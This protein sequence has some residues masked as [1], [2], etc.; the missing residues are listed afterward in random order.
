MCL[1]QLILILFVNISFVQ[2]TWSQDERTFRD[3]IT[4]SEREDSTRK[5]AAEYK[6][7]V[8]SHR[9]YLDMNE[10]GAPESFFTSK[11]DGEDWLTLFDSKDREV[12]RYRFETIGPWSRLFRVQMRRISKNV[13]VLLLYFFEGTTRYINF[14]GTTRVYFLTLENNDFKSLSTYK[15]PYTWDEYRSFKDHYHQRKFEVSLYDFDEDRERE[16]AV[17]YGLITRVYKFLGKGKWKSY[18]GG[19]F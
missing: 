9:Y 1:K 8:R 19:S 7:Q 2:I 17:R 6:Y 3:I 4:H 10:D 14:Q 18:A 12:Y 15:G 5:Q 13:K 11:R 16:V